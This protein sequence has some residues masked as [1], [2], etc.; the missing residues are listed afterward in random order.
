MATFSTLVG[1]NY[2]S[3]LSRTARRAAFQFQLLAVTV[4]VT[5]GLTVGFLA[6]GDRVVF[7][8]IMKLDARL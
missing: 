3:L 6:P 5:V 2:R 4:F 8:G 7:C 1:A